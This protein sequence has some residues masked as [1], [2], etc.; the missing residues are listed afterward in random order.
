[1]DVDCIINTSV[2]LYQ[3]LNYTCLI[4]CQSADS[5]FIPHFL[6]LVSV[7]STQNNEVTKH[8]GHMCMK[9]GDV[10]NV[11][12]VRT[13]GARASVCAHNHG[14]CTALW[15]TG[16]ICRGKWKIHCMAV[17]K[18][19]WLIR[20]ELRWVVCCAELMES[21]LKYWD[22][23]WLLNNG[24]KLVHI[25]GFPLSKLFCSQAVYFECRHE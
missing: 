3:M 6:Q 9:K 16:T 20:W 4:W 21:G 13:N 22:I 15:K 5:Y 18:R 12:Q 23:V 10:T 14:N 19:D 1:M 8:D 11:W 7:N 17:H 24:G 2:H 25:V